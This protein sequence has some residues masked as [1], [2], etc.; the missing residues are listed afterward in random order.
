MG[1]KQTDY[2]VHCVGLRLQKW[3][4]DVIALVNIDRNHKLFQSQ[5]LRFR[6]DRQASDSTVFQ[7]HG[8]ALCAAHFGLA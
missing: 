8:A 7:P 6:H 4:D 1:W 2:K 5:N 3:I